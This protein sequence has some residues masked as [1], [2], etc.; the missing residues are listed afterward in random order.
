V[1]LTG[2]FISI[3]I[4]P[5]LLILCEKF[6]YYLPFL[7]PMPSTVKQ[8]FLFFWPGPTAGKARAGL[9][10][11]DSLALWQ[12]SFLRLSPGNSGTNPQVI[13]HRY[14]E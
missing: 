8:I 3:F 6:L 12:V 11:G 13:G 10:P 2:L 1:A 5:W 14:N 9:I 4:D 7:I